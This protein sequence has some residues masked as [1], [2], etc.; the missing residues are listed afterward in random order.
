MDWLR[1]LHNSEPMSLYSFSGSGAFP[2]DAEGRLQSAS[3]GIV[4]SL[5]PRER[6]IYHDLLLAIANQENGTV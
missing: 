2:H 3:N 1:R 4:D 6:Q 5:S